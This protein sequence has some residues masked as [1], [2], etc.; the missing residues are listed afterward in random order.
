[1]KAHVTF[2]RDESCEHSPDRECTPCF[3]DGIADFM[4]SAEAMEEAW[5]NRSMADEASEDVVDSLTVYYGIETVTA[6]VIT[7]PVG[8]DPQEAEKQAKAGGTRAEVVSTF[9]NP[10]APL[11]DNPSSG[12]PYR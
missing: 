3:K 9:R 11:P 2:V 5:K 1:M 6:P 12:G 4:A 7:V 10:D 8:T